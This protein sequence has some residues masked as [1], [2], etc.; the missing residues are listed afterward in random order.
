VWNGRAFDLLQLLL[1]R[2]RQVVTT[3]VH[4]VWPTTVVKQ[5]D[6]RF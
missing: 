2:R 6:V 5:G 3:V 4:R 1:I